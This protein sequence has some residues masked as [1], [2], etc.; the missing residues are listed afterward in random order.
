[1]SAMPL[2]SSLM[3]GYLELEHIIDGREKLNLMK[4]IRG[5]RRSMLSRRMWIAKI[6]ISV[7]FRWGCSVSDCLIFF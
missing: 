2:I 1:M 5:I 3:S 7:A 6:V 4:R